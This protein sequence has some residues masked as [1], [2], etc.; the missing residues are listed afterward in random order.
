MHRRILRFSPAPEFRRR[1]GPGS[2]L[3][4]L[5]LALC[6]TALTLSAVDALAAPMAR[7]AAP[8]AIAR[9]AAPAALL[10]VPPAQAVAARR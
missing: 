2:L 6:A 10:A 8:S 9:E 1:P 7:K 5:L 4:G 3:R